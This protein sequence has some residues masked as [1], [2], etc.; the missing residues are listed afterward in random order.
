[1]L[2]R[3][4]FRGKL[5]LLLFAATAIAVILAC[6]GLGFY[7]RSSFRSSRVRELSTL[8]ETM[9]ANT[10]ASIA[11]RDEAT[12]R[13]MLGAL[14]ADAE[15]VYACVYD[16]AGQRFA[17]YRRAGTTDVILVEASAPR[18]ALFRG[19]FV[20]VLQDIFLHQ[21]KAGSIL[22]VS[23]T[24]AFRQK[25]REYA[26]IA[27]LVFVLATLTALAAFSRL[28]RLATEPIEQLSEIATQVSKGENYSLRAK[29]TTRDEIGRLVTAFNQMLGTI[30][31]R[32][33]ALQ[34]ANDELEKRVQ[35]RTAYLNALIAN[36][37]LAILVL[38]AAEK[39]QL[40]NPSFEQLFQYVQKDI[41]G[42]SADGL[43]AEGERLSEARTIS[44]T[45][46]GGMQATV[47]TTRKKKDGTWVDVEVH[48]VPLTVNGETVGSLNI[49]Q[50]ISERKHAEDAMQRAKEQAEAS[51]RA[52]S[53][54][55]AN[56]SHEIRTPLNGVIG[57]T[58]LALDTEL[59][60]EQ[61]EYL[62]TVKLS[63]DS[64]LGVVNDILDF[65]K[66][67]AGRIEL[68][69]TDFSLRD[70][71]ETTLKTLAL[72]A[73]EKG[74]ELLCEIAPDVP[75]TVR[76]DA[77]RLRQVILNLVG[78]AIKFTHKGEV[79]LA[80]KSESEQGE[81]RLLHFT[82][83]DTGIGIPPEKQQAIFEPFSQAD[84]STTRKY[85][86]TGLGLTISS[87]L[88]AMMGGK[89]WLESQVERGSRFHFT[90]LVKSSDPLLQAGVPTSPEFLRGTRVLIVD[91]NSTNRRILCG[92]LKRWEMEPEETESGEGALKAIGAALRGGTPFNLI[93][94]DMHMPH[95]DGFSFVEAIR[96]EYNDATP[97]IM[98]LTSAGHR[99]DAERCRRLGIAAYLLKPIRQ[100]ELREAVARVLGARQ[101]T[102]P[103]PL[104]T[105]YSLQDARE[106]GASLS[107]LLAE[108]N[109]VNQRL[110]VRLLEK[111][112]HRVSV[113]ENGSQALK[114]LERS[115]FDVVFMDVQMPEM[116]GMEATKRI[117]E[118]ERLTGRHQFIVALTAHAMKGDEE[119]CREAGMDAYL[120]KPIR[121]QELDQILSIT[122]ERARQRQDLAPAEVQ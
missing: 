103:I 43:L 37:P 5:T 116:D 60:S 14:H 10:A 111:R 104:I 36:S 85:G 12:A 13:E 24:A 90:L 26:E 110:A 3:L 92:M 102:G 82:V 121:T 100:S 83:S 105:R 112:G 120:S 108:D 107:I 53:E 38:D 101:Q 79:Q 65:S 97:M 57:M 34:R 28:L 62:E 84:T 6:F 70:C 19:G 22:I 1:M 7:E 66:I 11:F 93:L 40:C 20:F 122:H 71:L 50:D 81:S 61:R 32:D 89:I 94:T 25:I 118:A 99:G 113:A 114:A 8:A 4:S 58:E 45:A 117:R 98:M 35:Q 67:E 27:L 39:V 16:G 51:S 59:N 91:D 30:E 48:A 31:Q 115:H 78:N 95:M 87:R 74:L 29:V 72:R 106:P 41:I 88:I 15:V 96:R 119:R 42:K 69:S 44:K 54:F 73:D 63:A 21:Q 33:E 49:Y 2:A 109:L 86:G 77:A 46:L 55:L 47:I 9:G 76:G 68:E 64:L 18:G 56:M 75:E 17:E 52:K 23:D 80:V